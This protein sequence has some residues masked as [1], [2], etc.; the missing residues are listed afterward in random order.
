MSAPTPPLVTFLCEGQDKEMGVKSTNAKL[1][2]Y[3]SVCVCVCVCVCVRA[4]ACVC[5]CI[6]C[7]VCVCC[8][9]LQVIMLRSLYAMAS[10]SSTVML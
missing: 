4:R 1:W 3:F 10:V 9:D 7:V 5:V 8:A 2:M 6:L